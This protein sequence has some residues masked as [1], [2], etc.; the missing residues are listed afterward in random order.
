[1]RN[2]HDWINQ[3]SRS[4]RKI[5]FHTYKSSQLERDIVQKTFL[6]RQ[7]TTNFADPFLGCSSLTDA[8]THKKSK[9]PVIRHVMVKGL[10]PAKRVTN[11]IE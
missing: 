5:K 3:T 7:T 4:Q 6:S 11:M 1:M 10:E 2:K 8:D 9:I